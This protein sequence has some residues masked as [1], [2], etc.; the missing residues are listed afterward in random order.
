MNITIIPLG[1]G[2]AFSKAHGQSNFLIANGGAINP[3]YLAWDFGNQWPA[4]M[5][6]YCK[7]AGKGPWFTW[8]K[9]FYLSHNHADHNGGAEEIA[10]LA[11]FFPGIDRP[12]LH[13]NSIVLKDAWEKSWR[14]GLE[15]LSWGQLPEEWKE[16]PIDLSLYFQPNY[17]PDNGSFSIQ[18][19]RYEPFQ[20][21]HVRNKFSSMPCYGT[22]I[23]TLIGTRIMITSDTQF[24]PTSLHQMYEGVDEIWHDCE[25][26]A[27]KSGVHAHFEDLCTLPDSIKSKMML[28]HYNENNIPDWESN[29]FKGI[30]EVHKE[31]S[32][33]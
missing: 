32:Y 11:F 24:N 28:Y 18:G 5:D 9:D 22:L 19:N 31:Y 10:F 21:E 15:S 23:T 2:G 17:V 3:T 13:G 6:D 14:G 4:M 20:V 16:K 7:V 30:A 27:I 8:L 33:A 12:H 1:T 26:G 25:T 29:G